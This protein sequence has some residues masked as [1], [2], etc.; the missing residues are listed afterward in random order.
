MVYFTFAFI[1]QTNIPVF[2]QTSSSVR[3]RYSDFEWLKTEL[4]RDSKVHDGY[5]CTCT[6]IAIMV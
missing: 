4:E 2:K 3:R 6:C 5:T 1:V